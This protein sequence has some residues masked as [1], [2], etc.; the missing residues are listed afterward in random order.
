[1]EFVTAEICH[2]HTLYSLDLAIPVQA[3]VYRK[4]FSGPPKLPFNFLW[5]GYE[6]AVFSGSSREPST[7]SPESTVES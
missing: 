4:E 2:L 3:K 5:A 1:M 6:T 7:E